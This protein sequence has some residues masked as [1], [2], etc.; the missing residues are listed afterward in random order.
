M[1]DGYVDLVERTGEPGLNI[2]RTVAET[3]GWSVAVVES[4]DGGARFEVT[5]VT[6]A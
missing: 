6:P 2:V 4:A 1:M 3:H 5:G